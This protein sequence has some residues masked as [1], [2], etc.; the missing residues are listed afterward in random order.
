LG[1][2]QFAAA[3]G[4]IGS[5]QALLRGLRGPQEMGHGAESSKKPWYGG[6][7]SQKVRA[8]GQI[9]PPKTI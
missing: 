4:G 9:L 2:E 6:G 1:I 3:F 8:W 5:L 7:T